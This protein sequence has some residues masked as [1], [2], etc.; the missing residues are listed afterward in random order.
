V[1]KPT[2]DHTCDI[3]LLAALEEYAVNTVR[4]ERLSGLWPKVGS[5]S[6]SNYSKEVS[7]VGDLERSPNHGVE[8]ARLPKLNNCL[9]FANNLGNLTHHALALMHLASSR[10]MLQKLGNRS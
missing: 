9:R 5:D 6:L 4:R 1:W 8:N 2:F 10:P 7:K 3:F